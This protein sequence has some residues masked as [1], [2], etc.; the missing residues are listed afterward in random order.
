MFQNKIIVD[1][2]PRFKCPLSTCNAVVHEND[3]NAVLD[4]KEPAL[5]RYMSIVHRRYLQ[6]KQNKHSI[7]AALPSSDI[8]RCP[9]CR[10]IY[11]HV[12]GCNYVICANSACNTAF[13][14]LCEKPMGR[15][16]SHFTTGKCGII[17]KILI[18]QRLELRCIF[19]CFIRRST[20]V[21]ILA[22]QN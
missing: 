1:G 5:E 13:C 12:V 6:Y 8:K 3:I 16:S 10:S 15:P 19:C 2:H 22:N 7:M 4:E 20:H 21:L 11:M 9:L 14:W 18:I 17:S